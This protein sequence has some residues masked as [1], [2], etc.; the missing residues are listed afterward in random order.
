M[1]VKR[2]TQEKGHFMTKDVIIVGRRDTLLKYGITRVQ[3]N[4][5]ILYKMTHLNRQTLKSNPCGK[6]IVNTVSCQLNSCIN[7]ESLIITVTLLRF[8][9]DIDEAVK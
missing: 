2:H 1:E 8:I 9:L 7:V 3:N 4:M 6:L 5:F